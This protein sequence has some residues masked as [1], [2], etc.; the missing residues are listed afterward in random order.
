MPRNPAHAFPRSNLAYAQR[1]AGRFADA[2]AVAE[3]ALARDLETLPMRRL[4]YQLAELSG[5]RVAAQRQIDWAAGRTRS[6]DLTGARAQVAAFGGHMADARRLYDETIAV[7]TERGFAQV[8]SGYAAQAALTEAL[9]GYKR[10]AMVRAREVLRG[11]A[12]YEPQLCE[13]AMEVANGQRGTNASMSSD[14]MQPYRGFE[15]H[16]LRQTI[17]NLFIYYDAF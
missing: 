13:V 7:A 16:P 6:F 10:E 14:W 17:L 11:A 1:G 3:E 2:R 12:P 15:S 8:A 5:D 4:L 9:F